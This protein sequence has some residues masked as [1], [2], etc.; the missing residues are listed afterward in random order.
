ML[1]EPMSARPIRIYLSASI[2]NDALNL[3]LR[4]ALG[5]RFHLV[6]PQEFT[7]TDRSHRRFPRAIYQ[8]CIDEM[9]ACDAGVLLL[10]AFGIDCASEAG[11][12]AA[13]GKPLIGIVQSNLRFLQHWMVK[14]N[15]TGMVSLDPIVAERVA[16]DPILEELPARSCAGWDGLAPAMLSL[17]TELDVP[18]TAAP[19]PIP[20]SRITGG[21]R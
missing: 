18:G 15:L 19:S 7:P 11:W 21:H 17:L 2:A 1:G 9:E 8:A 6:L 14:G 16:S 13:R 4:Q 12:F 10:D 3:R 5:E 20:L